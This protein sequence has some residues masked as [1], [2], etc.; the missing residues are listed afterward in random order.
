[1]VDAFA[2]VRPLRT[3]PA[4]DPRTEIDH[5]FLRG[6]TARDV[7]APRTTASDHLPVAATIVW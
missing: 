4:D 7:T 1:L 3:S 6:A 2:A 5:L